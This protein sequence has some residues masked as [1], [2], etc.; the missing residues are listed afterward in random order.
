MTTIDQ[1]RSAVKI[2][3]VEGREDFPVFIHSELDD[4]GLSA[5]EFRV[6]ARLA[7]RCGRGVAYESVVSMARD[8][9]VSD[10]SI[11][12]ALRVLVECH[13]IS[14]TIRPG[15]TTLYTLNGRKLWQ[16]KKLL[17][18]T[19]DRLFPR[20]PKPPV[21]SDNATGGATTA[22]AG[23]TPQQGVEVT[24]QRDEGSPD[25]GFPPKVL[26]NTH[27]RRASAPERPP[28]AGVGVSSNYSYE[29][30]KRYAANNRDKAGVLLGPGWLKSSADG[31]S[32]ELIADWYARQGQE[33]SGATTPQRDTSACPDC[34]G[35]NFYYPAGDT[36]EGRLRGT[37][38]CR[39]LR[40]D[41][42]PRGRHERSD[43]TPSHTASL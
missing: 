14:E 33:S 23:V 26:Q 32:D 6:Y 35:T 41:V 39:H 4:Y 27:T 40:L 11:Q 3:V 28:A 38:K 10:R 16:D 1:A 12:R 37:A 5:I 7:R 42:Q 13:L 20:K 24:P 30:R 29:Q 21:T 15:K 34:K 18:A 17:K 19:R 22:V 36:Q 43:N 2:E 25:Q 9:E 31:S 8:F